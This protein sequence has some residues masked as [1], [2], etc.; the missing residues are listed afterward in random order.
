LLLVVLTGLN[1]FNYLDRYVLNAV[2][3]PMAADFGL[4]Y[5]DSGRLF[6]AFMLGYFVTSPFFGFL[7]DRFSRKILIALGI[8]VWSLGTVL[9]GF[10]QGFAV[11]L[12]FRA[13]VGLGEASYATLSPS[14]ISDSWP[15]GKRN[16]AIT[17]FYLAIPVGSAL[18]YMLG[19]EIATHWGW[20]QAF[21][22]AGAP[23]LFLALVLLPFR[24]PSR[25]E[26]DRADRAHYRKAGVGDI[27]RLFV[28]RDY[29]LVVWGYV[30]YTFALGAFAFW[31][32]TFLEKV[33]GLPL[34]RADNFFGAVLVVA[35]LL[36]SLAGGLLATWWQRRTPAG[37]A[38]LLFFSMLGAVPV[39]FYAL[40]A[41][42]ITTS[43]VF[44][45]LSIFFIFFST[46]PVNTLILETAPVNVRSSAMAISIFLIHLFG[47]MPSPE[48]VGRIADRL[49]GDL[50]TALL[51]L[52]VALAC[53]G[54]LWLLL[55]LKTGK[56]RASG[57]AAGAG[58]E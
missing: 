48:I 4:G 24:E 30:A 27:L 12:V 45:G 21:Y 16:T 53:A 39:S 3:T 58:H 17:V 33:H 7:G 28:N 37:Y 26:S 54:A 51:L 41:G 32:P 47:D 23:G 2:R 9:T 29:S 38:L 1:L 8:F 35:G 19:G 46:G 57:R 5:G 36:G 15:A 34:D 18:G 40:L 22:W 56:A 50:R 52:P 10:A 6:T 44:L 11:L 49:A 13:L 31:G 20:R 55:A 14:L 42:D 43:M 25:G